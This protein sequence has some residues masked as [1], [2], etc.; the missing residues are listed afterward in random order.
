MAEYWSNVVFRFLQ[1]DETDPST[2]EIIS[3]WYNGNSYLWVYKYDSKDR[4]HVM[5]CET[6]Q[7]LYALLN[8]YFKLLAWD[9]HPYRGMQ[10]LLPGMPPVMMAM[11]DVMA[12][13]N[14]IENLLDITFELSPRSVP[15]SKAT[16]LIK[17][18]HEVDAMPPL[19]PL[20]NNSTHR[21][22]CCG[23]FGGYYQ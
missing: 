1:N 16:E 23:T 21:S 15:L 18:Y 9:T 8:S 10:I 17:E 13:F 2:D 6:K 7:Q 19:V 20:H 22:E 5:E 4:R 11:D 12:A 14:T 3:L